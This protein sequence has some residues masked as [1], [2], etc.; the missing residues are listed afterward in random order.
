VKYPKR[1]KYLAP[2][3]VM[4]DYDTNLF[5]LKCESMVEID[6]I[7]PF[8]EVDEFKWVTI[9][10]ALPLIHITQRATLLKI[11]EGLEL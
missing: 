10:E 11:R 5:D 1:S 8:P 6:G 7:K 3:L 9:D 4:I 2:F